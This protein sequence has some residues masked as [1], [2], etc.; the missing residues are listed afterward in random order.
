MSRRFRFLPRYIVLVDER[1]AGQD[2]SKTA[3]AVCVKVVFLLSNHFAV[4]V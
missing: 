2:L 4:G 3:A 1:K